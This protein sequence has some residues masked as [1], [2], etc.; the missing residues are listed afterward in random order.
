MCNNMSLLTL[1]TFEFGDHIKRAKTNQEKRQK[2]VTKLEEY[3]EFIKMTSQ[4]TSQKMQKM[5]Q[6]LGI[7]PGQTP[8]V[9]ISKAK[10]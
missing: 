2:A 8:R 4:S 7:A 5:T 9:Q 10:E 1:H 3:T 6:K